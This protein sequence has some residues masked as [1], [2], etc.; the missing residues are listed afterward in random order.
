MKKIIGILFVLLLTYANFGFA[1]EKVACVGDSITYGIGVK[2]RENKCY[3]VLLANMLGDKY[4]VKNFGFRGRS[5][6]LKSKL[7]YTKE[8]MYKESLEFLPNIVVIML[9]TNDANEKNI[10]FLDNFKKDFSDLVDSYINLST[11]PKVYICR[12]L[13]SFPSKH[14]IKEENLA[15]IRKL[16][17]E[18]ASEKKLSVIDT[19]NLFVDKEA[20]IPDKIHPNNKGAR[21]LAEEVC[22]TIQK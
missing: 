18:V 13:P 14:P 8:K 1:V 22:K 16:V 3:P 15:K 11:K 17:D 7:P 2:D 19:Y 9:G 12:I 20:L 4:E 10:L 5:V 21:L 6:G